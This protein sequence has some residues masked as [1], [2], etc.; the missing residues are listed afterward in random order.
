ML[1]ERYQFDGVPVIE[2][3]EVRL[4]ARDGLIARL[5]DGTYE[6]EAVPCALCAAS[7][8]TAL[9]AKDRYGL[10]MD[11]VA[12]RQCGL[13]QTNPRMTADSYASFY[14]NEY[15]ALE[16]GRERPTDEFFEFQISR[17][18]VIYRWLEKRRLLPPPGGNVLDVGCG[19]G[20]NLVPFR[21][22]GY[23]VSGVDLG[24]AYVEYGRDAHALDL[25][26]GTVAD[27]AQPADLVIYRHVFEHLLDL[28]GELAELTKHL[29]PNA[30]VYVE[31]PGVKN[32]V[33]ENGDFLRYCQIPHV[34]HFSKSTL[35]LA[36]A[37]G[38]FTMLD[39][40]ESV[41]AAFV[42]SEDPARTLAPDLREHD[43]VVHSL[44]V[45]ESVRPYR[46][47]TAPVLVPATRLVEAIR[48]EGPVGW[49]RRRLGGVRRRGVPSP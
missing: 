41:R 15:R 9:S 14:D 22:A 16:L 30:V 34:F 38:G 12:C 45:R 42:A 33:S 20:G 43:A 18:R 4:E 8:F 1:T 36:L 3:N 26:T 6:M 21:D 40:D 29:A 46:R 23:A 39:G 24:S 13:V 7:S 37:N 25:Q 31:V 2:M 49:L 35:E 11:V 47:A 48:T 5:A 10:P 32:L 28:E 27:V 44:H 17:G 19:A